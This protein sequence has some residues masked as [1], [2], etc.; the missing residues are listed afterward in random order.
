MAR[1]I[2]NP[3]VHAPGN[4]QGEHSLCGL[5]FDA[6]ETGDVDDPVIF[7]TAGGLVTC[8]ECRALI[9]YI[10]ESFRRFRFTS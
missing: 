9:N 7:A 4:G 10:R 5:A 2:A 3:A 1:R 8:P 6:Y